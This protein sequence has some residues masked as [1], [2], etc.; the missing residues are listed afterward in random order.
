MIGIIREIINQ[1]A[2]NN[3]RATYYF[4]LPEKLAS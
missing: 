2:I 3:F 1:I 4:D